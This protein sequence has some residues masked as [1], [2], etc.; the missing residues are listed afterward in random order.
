MRDVE[1]L[2]SYWTLAG[3]S[4]PHSEIEY[5]L[6]DFKDRVV[7][8]AKAGFKGI[9]I[10]EVDLAHILQRRNLKEMR[11]IFE[12]NGIKYVELEFLTDWFLDGEKKKRSD[13][14]RRMLLSAAETLE[15]RHIKVGDFDR[16][17]VL[18]DQRSL[19]RLRDL[20][21]EGEADARPMRFCGEE[22]DEKV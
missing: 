16:N 11:R 18:Q 1:L 10:K 3:A 2:A 17:T 8:A 12:D 20:S 9:G 5:S 4:Y 6:F 13:R 19:V 15:A 14:T 7:A 21:A 22:G